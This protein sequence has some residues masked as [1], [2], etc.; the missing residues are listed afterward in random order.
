MPFHC[1]LLHALRGAG[2][3]EFDSLFSK[4]KEPWFCR[5]SG[6]GSKYREGQTC[7]SVPRDE[8]LPIRESGADTQGLPYRMSGRKMAR[9]GSSG[10]SL[11]F[12]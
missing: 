11:L 6:T 3:N 7:V 2:S 12:L 1:I 4:R 5:K 9:R 8:S 10:S